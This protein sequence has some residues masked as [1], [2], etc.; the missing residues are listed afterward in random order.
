MYPIER[1]DYVNAYIGAITEEINKSKL[2]NSVQ[3]ESSGAVD[4]LYRAVA[5]KLSG[6]SHGTRSTTT[7]IPTA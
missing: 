6:W 7:P 3:P 5:D 2:L 1:E 4:R